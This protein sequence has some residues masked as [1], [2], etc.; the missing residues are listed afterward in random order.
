MTH[1]TKEHV[2]GSLS[3]AV[4]GKMV[5]PAKFREALS[6]VAPHLTSMTEVEMDDNGRWV[7]KRR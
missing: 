6:V 3:F 2:Q 7:R 5:T 4:N 1:R